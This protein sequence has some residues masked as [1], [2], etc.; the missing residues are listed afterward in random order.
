MTQA[1]SQDYFETSTTWATDADAREARSRRTAWTV[2]AIAA[3]IALLEAI[4]IVVL[5]PLKQTETVAMLVDRTTGYVQRVDPAQ[6]TALRADDALTQSLLAQYVN[7]RESYDRATVKQNYR[8]AAL[9]SAGQARRD[10]LA[11]MDPGTPGSPVNRLPN[12]EA[13]TTQVKS[14]SQVDPGRA[15]VRFDT[16]LIGRDG[17]QMRDGSW[18]S[19]VSYEFSDAAMSFDDRL[20]NPLGLQVTNYRRDAELPENNSEASS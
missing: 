2:A 13:I 15:F 7:A 20:L 10:Y 18:I 5:V 8:K 19:L 12:G 9:W 1:N 4:A 3:A 16:F 17:R 14:V 6:A 11:R